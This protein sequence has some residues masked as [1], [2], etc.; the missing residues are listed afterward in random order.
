[1]SGHIYRP[2]YDPEGILSTLPAIATTLCG[3]LTGQWLKSPK[4]MEERTNGMLIAGI[5]LIGAGKLMNLWFPINKSIWSSSY[6]VFTAGAALLFLGI[7]Y[8]LI[9]IKGYRA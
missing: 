2:T 8:W 5:V 7:S 9:D 6:V 3:V 1:M 4:N